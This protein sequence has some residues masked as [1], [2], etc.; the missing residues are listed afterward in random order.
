VAFLGALALIVVKGFVST[1]T[2]AN[3]VAAPAVASAHAE[4]SGPAIAPD[5]PSADDNAS[6]APPLL[7][8]SKALR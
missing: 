8:R 1:D 3:F 6:V 5:P 4:A 2:A 7:S